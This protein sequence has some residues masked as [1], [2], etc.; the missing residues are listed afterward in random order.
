M[1][2]HKNKVDIYDLC[3]TFLF[4]VFSVTKMVCAPQCN[5][6]C[7]GRGPRDCC[8]IECAAGCKGPLDEDCF[9]SLL[10]WLLNNRSTFFLGHLEMYLLV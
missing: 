6:R 8:H 7:F 9:V 3:I 2:T 5:G 4:S 1:F 10:L